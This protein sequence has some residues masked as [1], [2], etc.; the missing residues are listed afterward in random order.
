MHSEVQWVLTRQLAV[1]LV[2]AAFAGVLQGFHAFLSAIAGGSI[3]ML[4]AYAFARRSMR[5]PSPV[6]KQAFGTQIN[7][8]LHK[9]A[10][11]LLLF[12]AVFKGYEQ[13]LALPLLLTY[14][15]TIVV[16]WLALLRQP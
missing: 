1:T 4:G 3:S 8:E 9:F 16:Y 14:A 12:A 15:S 2:A 6:V 13:V 7:G 5:K 11:T 10:I